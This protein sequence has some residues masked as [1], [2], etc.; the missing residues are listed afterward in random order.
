VIRS[1]K[2]RAEVIADTQIYLAS[3]LAALEWRNFVDHTSPSYRQARQ[4]YEALRA[5]PD[6]QRRVQAIA[7]ERGESAVSAAATGGSKRAL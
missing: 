7:R 2:S 6:F 4:R 5:A 3:G 1:V